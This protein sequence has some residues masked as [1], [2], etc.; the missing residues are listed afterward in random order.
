MPIISKIGTRSTKVRVL[1]ALIYGMLILGGITMIYPFT[2]MLAGSLKSEADQREISM[3]PKF[4]ADDLILFRK[5]AESKHNVLPRHLGVAWGRSILSFSDIEDV[6]IR[7]PEVLDAYLVWRETEHNQW[8]RLGHT[9]GGRL[10]P[11]N[12]R[13]YRHEMSRRFNGD[14]DAYRKAMRVPIQGWNGVAPA[15]QQ[16]GRFTAI[17]SPDR[18]ATVAFALTRPVQD[19]VVWN[20]DG[21]FRLNFILQT[22]GQSI[23]DYNDSHETSHAGHREVFLSARAPEAGTLRADWESYVRNKARLDLIQIDETAADAFR[24]FLAQR[25]RDI[26]TYN[27]VHE[28]TYEQFDDVI[29]PRTTPD[30]TSAEVDWE[31]F[32]KE[33]CPLEALQIYGPRQSFEAFF[34]ARQ[35]AVVDPVRPTALPLEEADYVDCM[36]NTRALRWEFTTRNYKHVIEYILRH[37]NG[38]LNT[39]IYC[40]L[41]IVTALV[42]NP[43]AAY[44]LSRFRPASTYTILLFC[45]AT[46]A[47]PGEVTMIPAFLLLKRFPLWPLAGGFATMFITFMLLKRALPKW[48]ELWRVTISI[49]AASFV[50]AYLLP[51]ALGLKYV[52]LLN[53]FAALVL[54]GM[55]NGFMIFMLKGF[56]DSLPQE[57]YEAAEM[58]GANEWTKFWTITMSLSKPILAVFALGAFTGAYSAFM[59]ALIIIPDQSM[60]TLMIWVFQLQSEA[61]QAVVYASLVI[62]AIPTFLVFAFCQNLII[63][64]I[65]VPV[66]K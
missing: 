53:T 43:L 31:A 10:L 36:A 4:W 58:D 16:A 13:L 33:A 47:F 60:W 45:M 64:G 6:K 24:A 17:K 59:M 23:D 1:Y 27:A 57:L 37:G 22:Y 30:T 55:A 28:A 9:T 2:L 5:Y 15:P 42:V 46:M 25:H 38:I 19:R 18:A 65:V 61:N 14:V 56:F 7:D 32:I 21:D 49:A 41:A 20:V 66:E 62:T 50:G 26:A 44:A 35:G 8:W 63:R 29:M 34:A 52:S 51:I 48:P 54:P 12:G 11:I 40:L 3:Y 39:I